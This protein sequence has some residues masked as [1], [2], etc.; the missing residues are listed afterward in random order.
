MG[1]S[2][3]RRPQDQIGGGQSEREQEQRGRTRTF[4]AQSQRRAVGFDQHDGSEARE[5]PRIRGRLAQERRERQREQRRSQQRDPQPRISLAGRFQRPLGRQE[6]QGPQVDAPVLGG[7]GSAV[8]PVRRGELAQGRR[9]SPGPGPD[10][11][12]GG[13]GGRRRPRG[14]EHQL[15]LP[16]GGIPS[17]RPSGS[18]GGDGTSAEGGGRRGRRTH[19]HDAAEG[20]AGHRPSKKTEPHVDF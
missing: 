5:R 13:R 18:P 16:G 8:R 19:A 12:G 11:G 20:T 14:A 4:R 15:P 9:E 10:S 3:T 6:R 17:R 7:R 1:K 2:A